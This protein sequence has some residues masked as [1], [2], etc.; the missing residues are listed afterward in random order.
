MLLFPEHLLS[1]YILELQSC[2]SSD[3]CLVLS[4]ELIIWM[5]TMLRQRI[6]ET[7]FLMPKL[8]KLLDI[9]RMDSFMTG[10]ASGTLEGSRREPQAGQGILTLLEHM[11]SPS[12]MFFLYVPVL[13]SP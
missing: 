7:E 13:Y 2:S 3:H 5:L 10:V 8:L 6:K 4:V 11:I 9:N 1:H 12:G